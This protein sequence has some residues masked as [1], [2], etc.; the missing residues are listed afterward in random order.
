MRPD[1]TKSSLADIVSAVDKFDKELGADSAD[2]VIDLHANCTI[3][4]L[5]PVIKFAA[6]QRGISTSIRRGGYDTYFQELTSG[7]TGLGSPKPN[8]AFVVLH[9]ENFCVA[10]TSGAIDT[11]LTEERLD[12]LL[13]VI[14]SRKYPV[15]LTN[16]VWP[17][18]PTTFDSG[19][20]EQLIQ[21]LNAKIVQA[22]VESQSIRIVDVRMLVSLIGE[23][24]ALDRRSWYRHKAPYSL[25]LIREIADVVGL[26]AADLLGRS[27]KCLV[28]DCDNTLWGGTVGEDGQ[29]NIQIDP[30]TYPGNVFYKFQQQIKALER[31][32]VMIA[33]L[34]KNNEDDVLEIFETHQ[35]CVLSREDFVG[36]KINWESKPINMV[37]LV[38]ELNIGLDA[39]VFVD[40]SD[41]E[42]ELMRQAL[43]EVTTLQVPGKI[44][45]LP[46]LLADSNLFSPRRTT[47]EDASR[48]RMYREAAQRSQSRK[49]Q[50]S[51][52]EF[53]SMLNITAKIEPAEKA[54]VL[55]ISQLFAR[56]NQFMLTGYRPSEAELA[57]FVGSS[58]TFVY[59]LSSSDKFGDLGMIGALLLRVDSGGLSV[60]SFALSCRGLGRNLEDVLFEAAL[61]HAARVTG[62][63]V[64]YT[65]FERSRK[66]AQV[67]DLYDRYGMI[68]DTET[69]DVAEY[70]SPLDKIKIDVPEFIKVESNV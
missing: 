39:V 24:K 15:A 23:T 20:S 9:A 67:S 36:H 4:Q 33:L 47:A 17:M 32:G 55:R 54:N 10:D 46:S 8:L 3:D 26:V 48:T 66:N 12:E 65:R 64:V 22:A 60:L 40:D 70:H 59:A 21:M 61:S 31:R 37:A 30:H 27:K 28:L 7:S 29:E 16:F 11:A 56:T 45:Q 35:R 49:E 44:W 58:D 5:V 25:D 57:D 52:D 34:S 2:F 63:K 38:E 1:L 69:A 50:G 43:P 51:L 6:H 41:I 53:L 18:R 13:R 68:K 42:C 62:A 19:P 14:S